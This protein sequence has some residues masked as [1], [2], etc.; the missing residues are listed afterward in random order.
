MPSQSR[1]ARLTR[2]IAASGKLLT[3]CVT[4]SPRIVF[5]LSTMLPIDSDDAIGIGLSA[6]RLT[7]AVFAAFWS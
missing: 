6:E 7:H 3:V 5:S 4:R 1:S 2:S